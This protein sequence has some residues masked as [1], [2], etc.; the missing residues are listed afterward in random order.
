MVAGGSSSSSKWIKPLLLFVGSLVISWLALSYY[1]Q[2]SQFSLSP[3]QPLESATAPGT[4]VTKTDEIDQLQQQQ[5][6]EEVPSDVDVSDEGQEAVEDGADDDDGG[7]GG[8]D[9]SSPVPQR[10]VLENNYETPVDLYWINNQNPEGQ[11]EYILID[12]SITKF[13]TN[14]EHYS[15]DAKRYDQFVLKDTQ[16]N[17]VVFEFQVGPPNVGDGDFFVVAEPPVPVESEEGDDKDEDDDEDEEENYEEYEEEPEEV[18][19]E[20][21]DKVDDESGGGGVD[22]DN[23]DKQS[24]DEL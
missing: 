18:E 13:S 17:D 12:S 23:S 14:S 10:V 20:G 11:V 8:D 15:L 4:P 22:D 6:Q 1:P 16:T 19:Q 5:Q 24:S 9:G 3:S 2:F 7:D 21:E